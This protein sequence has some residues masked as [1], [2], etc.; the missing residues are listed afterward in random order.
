MESGSFRKVVY[1]D[2][3]TISNALQREYGGKVNKVKSSI[4]EKSID[5][6][7]DMEGSATAKLDVPF[8]SRLKFAFTGRMEVSYLHEWNNVTTITSTDVSQFE[9]V[10]SQLEHFGNVVLRDIKNSLTSLRMA[11]S[12]A[13]IVKS[14]PGDYN[15]REISDLLDQMEGYDVYDIGD[16]RYV[17]FN[18][19]AYLCNYKRQDIALTC[20]DLYCV[21]V[22]SFDIS[23]FNY[24][25]HV[26]EM[27]SLFDME[28]FAKKTL[29]EE[30]YPDRTG[31]RLDAER[32]MASDEIAQ[33]KDLYDV[34][35]AYVSGESV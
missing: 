23:D 21:K 1:F 10:K 14:N 15:L 13:R 16:N 5:A 7:F 20:L 6:Q 26:Q 9:E 28:G 2:R 29:E 17:R 31:E 35:C 11:A 24:L 22:G 25:K 32:L 12:F 8:V 18:Q 33:R 19:E 30:F 4:S 27:Q 3:E 34:V